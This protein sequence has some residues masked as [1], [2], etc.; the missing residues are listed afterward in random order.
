MGTQTSVREDSART[1]GFQRAQDVVL[2]DYDIKAM[3]SYVEIAKPRLR[4]HVLEAGAGAPVVMIHGGNSV[5]IMWAP[6]AERL[7]QDF[8]VFMPDRPGCGL[9]DQFN[10]RGTDLR[11]HGVDYI[12]STLDALGLER[13][14]LVGNSMGGFWAMAFAI[15]HPDRVTKLAL[16]GEPAGADGHPRLFH[17]LV[18]TR[19][20]N[21]LLYATALR[22]QGTAESVRSGLAKAKLVADPNR[23]PEHLLECFAAGALLPGA[24]KAWTTMVEAAFSPHLGLF[25]RATNGGTASLVP[26]LGKVTAPTLFQWGD[27]DPLG[28]PETGRQLAAKMPNARVQVVEDAG[29]LPWMDHPELC[30]NS[31]AGFLA[32]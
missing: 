10:Y 22:P 25:Y 6:V 28:T 27:K 7:S 1:A 12:G 29:H 2:A 20:V 32:E 11:Q 15:A 23:V 9:T 8:R 26:E 24:T 21:S 13:A 16:L 31:L 19:G 4:I 14:A 30:G 3:S 17:K 18:G 5:A